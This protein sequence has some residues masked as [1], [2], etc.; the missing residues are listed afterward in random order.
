MLK[1]IYS[2]TPSRGSAKTSVGLYNHRRKFLTSSYRY[3]TTYWPNAET[4]CDC[5]LGIF[6]PH[7]VCI[8]LLN[9][10][11]EK[12][13]LWHDNQ[14]GA[15][16]SSIALKPKVVVNGAHTCSALASKWPLN[17]Y[18]RL[19]CDTCAREVKCRNRVTL[20]RFTANT[21]KRL[22][23]NRVNLNYRD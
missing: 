7:M 1:I 6:T 14:F 12:S 4:Y 5:I 16:R 22:P 11:K 21:D 23:P 20:G 8:L 9:Q 3:K 19:A 15:C 13:R 2:S 17:N 18:Q 10:S